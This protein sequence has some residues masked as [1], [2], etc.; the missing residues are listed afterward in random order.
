MKTQK[1]VLIYGLLIAVILVWAFAWPISKIGLHYMPPLW[2][3]AL[4]LAIG[5]ITIFIVL[6]FRK[7]I[8]I[9]SQKDLPLILSIGLLQ[10]LHQCIPLRHLFLQF[11]ILLFQVDPVLFVPHTPTVLDSHSFGNLIPQT[12]RADL[13]QKHEQS[14]SF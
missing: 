6:L 8:Q 10:L 4:R 14:N 13:A 11:S 12:H 7:K 9:P 3:T 2:Y 1:T 5:F